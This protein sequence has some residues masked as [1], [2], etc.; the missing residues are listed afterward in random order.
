IICRH[1]ADEIYPAVS[2]ASIIA[3]VIRDREI[4]NAT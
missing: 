1:K 2:A 4:E 3:K